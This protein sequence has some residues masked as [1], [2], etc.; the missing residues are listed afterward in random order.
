MCLLTSLIEKIIKLTE[1]SKSKN[2]SFYKDFQPSDI[3]CIAKISLTS[4]ID[5]NVPIK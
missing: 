2:R 5:I 3:S 1:A 4:P